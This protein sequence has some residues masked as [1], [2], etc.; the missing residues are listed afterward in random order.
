[1]R[2]EITL[3]SKTLKYTSINNAP[4]GRDEAAAELSEQSSFRVGP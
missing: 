4:Y 2:Y 3:I 1:M